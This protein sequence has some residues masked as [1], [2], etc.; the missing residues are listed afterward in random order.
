MVRT[1]AP[2]VGGD[3]LPKNSTQNL[4]YNEPGMKRR[5]AWFIGLGLALFAVCLWVWRGSEGPSSEFLNGSSFYFAETGHN[6]AVWYASPRPTKD[7]LQV[8]KRERKGAWT[9]KEIGGVLPQWTVYGAYGIVHVREASSRL[10]SALGKAY[11]S[12]PKGTR[13]II[14][15]IRPPTA[16]DRFRGWLYGL[17]WQG[18]VP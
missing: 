4:R 9:Y 8:A 16:L 6:A 7:V 13:T 14:T 3:H 2:P 12:I 10:E 15:I 11:P 18:S 17:R 5:K 1:C